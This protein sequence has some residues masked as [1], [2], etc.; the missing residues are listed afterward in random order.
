MIIILIG[1]TISNGPRQGIK[2][3]T[4]SLIY[5]TDSSPR[6]IFIPVAI[7]SHSLPL[8]YSVS[9]H[10]E[11]LSVFDNSPM[12]ERHSRSGKLRVEVM[13]NECQKELVGP[14]WHDRAGGEVWVFWINQHLFRYKGDW[15]LAGVKKQTLI[16]RTL[17]A[18]WSITLPHAQILAW[19]YQFFLPFLGLR[20]SI[21][22]LN[23]LVT[24]IRKRQ[25]SASVFLF[26]PVYTKYKKRSRKKKELLSLPELPGHF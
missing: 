13:L 7:V 18:L 24:I 15:N 11:V 8:I 10:I 25:S 20:C 14:F 16:S 2:I 22:K 9:P 1:K 21:E 19:L 5:W 6:F 23:R 17:K 26:V 4:K 3:S 12:S